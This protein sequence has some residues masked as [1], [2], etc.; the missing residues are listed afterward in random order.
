MRHLWRS[1]GGRLSEGMPLAKLLSNFRVGRDRTQPSFFGANRKRERREWETSCHSG[2]AQ[3][4]ADRS[5]LILKSPSSQFARTKRASANGSVVGSR[6]NVLTIPITTTTRHGL[7]GRGRSE[8]QIIGTTIVLDTLN[9]S[10]VIAPSKRNAIAKPVK[11][12]QRWTRHL[13]ESPCQQEPISCVWSLPATLQRW[14]RGSLKSRP[15]QCKTK[16][17]RLIAKR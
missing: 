10:S 6:P 11:E 4:A 1:T 15:C 17:W 7:P 2:T 5:S 16:I 14:T 8:I 13:P 9:T 3:S 12:L